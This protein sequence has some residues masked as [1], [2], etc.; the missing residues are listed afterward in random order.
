M[1]YFNFKAYDQ[2]DV[3]E[4]FDLPEDDQQLDY[5]EEVMFNNTYL[6]ITIIYIYNILY[7]FIKILFITIIILKSIV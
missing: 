4:T 5:A 7:R 2:P 1:I 3:Y 6:L